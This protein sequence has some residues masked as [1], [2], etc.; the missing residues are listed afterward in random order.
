[1]LDA[2]RY[3]F[4]REDLPSGHTP[5]T[6]LAH[7]VEQ[8]LHVRY[9]EGVPASVRKQIQH[10]LE[11]IQKLDVAGYFLALQAIVHL[12]ESRG[13]LC[14]GRGAGRP[15]AVRSPPGLTTP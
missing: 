6:W 13:I 7:L 1:S 8:G 3:Q 11:L 10:E 2:L 15:V 4:P 12:P 9:P 14:Q 5:D